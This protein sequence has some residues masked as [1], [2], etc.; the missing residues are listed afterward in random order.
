MAV[1]AVAKVTSTFAKSAYS[2]FDE[3]KPILAALLAVNGIHG[4]KFLAIVHEGDPQNPK[5]QYVNAAVYK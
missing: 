3:L 1:I 4:L 2:S 5:W